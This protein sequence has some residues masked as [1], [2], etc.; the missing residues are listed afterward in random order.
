MTGQLMKGNEAMA[1]AAVLAGCRFFSG[2]PITPQNEILEYLSVR[3]PEIGGTFV[4]AES[5]LAAINMA[6]G[7]AVAGARTM[8][9]SAGPG[10]S[11]LQE[12]LSYLV[13]GDIPAV[14]VDVARFGSGIGEIC[15][16]QADY[17]LVT[18]GNGHGDSYVPV[19]APASVQEGAELT[20]E[21]FELAE[22]YRHPVILLSD[23]AIGQMMEPVIFR[24]AIEIDI[25]RFDWT[26][27]GCKITDPPRKISNI[28]YYMPEYDDYL[29]AKYQKMR[30]EEQRW[31]SIQVSD[32]DLVLVAYGI[33]SRICKE[34]V[35][36]ARKAGLKLG[37][38]R[39]ISLVPFPVRAFEEVPSSCK[40]LMTV[41]MN[42][43][44]QMSDDVRLA[45]KCRVP[46][47]SYGTGM[48]VPLSNTIISHA[49]NILAGSIH[50]E[51]F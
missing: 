27:K 22:K 7:A 40:A 28:H 4:Q 29:R 2:Y 8:T 51:V 35:S 32:A 3:L 10:F 49:R 38:I 47:Y 9:G 25:D 34:A 41:E 16:G 1:E 26:V 24:D 48:H 45:C 14:I 12:G 43:T 37:L 11:L 30:D 19:L 23:A 42:I 31:E 46:V 44:G 18:R 5:E 36:R 13:A 15:Q 6:L 39:C 50:S 17:G 33:S 21:A 20:F